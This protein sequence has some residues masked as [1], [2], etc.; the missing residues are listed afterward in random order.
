M[1]SVVIKRVSRHVQFEAQCR[2]TS[3]HYARLD[4]MMVCYAYQSLSDWSE[5]AFSLIQR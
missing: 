5:L 4:T 2:E 3:K 1:L